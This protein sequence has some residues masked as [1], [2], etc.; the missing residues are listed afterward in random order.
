MIIR[1]TEMSKHDIL[2]KQNDDRT[3]DVHISDRFADGL[4]FDEMLG[5]VASIAMPE[6]RMCLTWLKTSKEKGVW[7]ERLELAV[8]PDIDKDDSVSLPLHEQRDLA[9]FNENQRLNLSVGANA[10]LSFIELAS[11]VF[12]V[13]VVCAFVLTWFFIFDGVIGRTGN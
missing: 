10:A 12:A 3:F 11:V 8:N 6:P 5:L 1:K 4:T 9:D 2:I 7:M 13:A